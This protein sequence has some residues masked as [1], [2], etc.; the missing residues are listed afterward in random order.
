MLMT[1]QKTGQVL[2]LFT[3]AHPEW[4][5][6][7]V[8]SQLGIPKS[9]AHALLATLTDIGLVER[10]PWGRYRLGWR[11][12]TLGRTVLVSTAY[13]TAALTLMRRMSVRYGETMHFAVWERGGVVYLDSAHP[14]HTGRR[15]RRRAG[16]R[17]G[18]CRPR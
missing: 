13:R 14:A 12:L 15:P 5:V 18:P 17:G 9:S 6:T 10:T 11:F 16:P 7:E 3:V 2:D 4:G 8:A 1:V